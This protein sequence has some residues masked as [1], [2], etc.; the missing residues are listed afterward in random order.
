MVIHDWYWRM[1]LEGA[2]TDVRL[3]SGDLGQ[4]REQADRFLDVTLK[5]AERTFQALAWEAK[6][7]VAIAEHDLKGARRY[8]DNALSITDS[9]DVPLAE[10]RVRATAA[11]IYTSLGLTDIAR[12]HSERGSTVILKLASSLP[13]DHPLRGRFL[14]A[15][16][17]S[18]LIERLN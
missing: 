15:P 12:Q 13:A 16:S 2:L 10:W 7:R 17:V 9:F 4:A 5:T 1:P 3:A 11:A 8:I 14:A 6:A 18:Q